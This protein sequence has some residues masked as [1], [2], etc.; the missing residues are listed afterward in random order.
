M[1]M[2]QRARLMMKQWV[3]LAFAFIIVHVLL[4][5]SWIIIGADVRHSRTLVAFEMMMYVVLFATIVVVF[6]RRLNSA[7]DPVVYREARTDRT[8]VVQGRGVAVSDNLGGRRTLTK[9][10]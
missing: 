2:S 4:F 1:N 5:V 8:S 10:S 6:C 7:A 3:L 9:N